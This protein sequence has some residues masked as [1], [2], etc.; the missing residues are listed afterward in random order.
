MRTLSH[1]RSINQDLLHCAAVASGWG[2]RTPNL[3]HEPRVRES[4]LVPKEFRGPPVRHQI[5]IGMDVEPEPGAFEPK[6]DQATPSLIRV[7]RIPERSGQRAERRDRADLPAISVREPLPQRTAQQP[8]RMEGQ[9][10]L[11]W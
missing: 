2:H 6:V 1:R 11:G 7:D 3:E 5:A 4:Q 9:P 10:E 8:W